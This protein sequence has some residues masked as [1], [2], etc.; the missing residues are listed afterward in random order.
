MSGPELALFDS[1]RRFRP[2]LVGIAGYSHEASK[3]SPAAGATRLR[4]ARLARL[5]D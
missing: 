4:A 3:G 1:L 5:R 2:D